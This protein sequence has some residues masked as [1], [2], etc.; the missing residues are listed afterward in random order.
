MDVD[1]ELTDACFEAAEWFNQACKMIK[2][3]IFFW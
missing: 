2:M 1:Y 3:N